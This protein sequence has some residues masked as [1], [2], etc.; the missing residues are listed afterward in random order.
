[1]TKNQSPRGLDTSAV[2]SFDDAY[3]TGGHP[4]RRARLRESGEYV[5]PVVEQSDSQAE[6]SADEFAP[7]VD[8]IRSGRFPATTALSIVPPAQALLLRSRSPILWKR[9]LRVLRLL[10][11]R[12]QALPLWWAL[13]CPVLA[14]RHQLLLSLPI[15]RHRP[16]VPQRRMLQ[17]RRLLR[18]VSSPASRRAVL[19]LLC[20]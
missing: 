12:R 18:R 9:V 19:S 7:T 4:S 6:S 3:S 20:A 2:S 11:L 8:D 5:D 14:G 1:M 10:V 15:R 16:I 13:I 17:R